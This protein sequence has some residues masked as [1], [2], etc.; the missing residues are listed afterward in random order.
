MFDRLDRP[1]PAVSRPS[2]AA[3]LRTA[4]A[5]EPGP[6]RLAALTALDVAALDA[7]DRVDHLVAVEQCSAW[8]EML[9]AQALLAVAGV[10]PKV[11]LT[12]G[13]PAEQRDIEELSV[14]TEVAAALRL[15]PRAAANRIESARRLV[16]DLAAAVPLMLSG[17]WHRG[18][19]DVAE[20]ELTGIAPAI[21]VAALAGSVA[22][23]DTDTPDRLRRR[24]RSTVARLDADAAARRV[25]RADARR[26]VELEAERDLQGRLTVRGP[27]AQV[28]WVH[29]IADQ[30]ARRERRR[31]RALVRAGA[32]DTAEVPTLAALR[33]DAVVEGMR[34]LA[35]R[36]PSDDLQDDVADQR[37]DQCA[38]DAGDEAHRTDSAVTAVAPADRERSARDRPPPRPRGGEAIVMITAATALGLADDPGV[39]PGYG[40][41][42]APIA[43]ELLADADSWR[44]FLLDEHSRVTHNGTTRYRPSPWLREL[45][46]ARDP[47]CTL[48]PC[49]RSSHDADLDHLETFDGSNT[50]PANLHPPCRTHHRLKTFGAWTLTRAPDGLITWI[51]LTGHRYPQRSEPE[52]PP[53]AP[54]SLAEPYLRRRLAS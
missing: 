9:R 42:P 53:A 1:A 11:D 33:A 16:G 48:E 30:W 39:V 43:R 13:L 12:P 3:A 52:W 36:T 22:H 50:T 2:A 51:S 49:S 41:V 20:A 5:L 38:D 24:L 44:A 34:L 17:S 4:C 7:G 6:A 14:E 47:R 31:L 54:V 32:L 27:W 35:H 10:E 23:A 28:A 19:L 15:P 18:H 40:P 45:V 37:A 21:A 8:L 26:H 46:T 29:R 25:R